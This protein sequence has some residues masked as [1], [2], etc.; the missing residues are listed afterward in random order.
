MSEVV[1]FT[2]ALL[3]SVITRDSIAHA[4]MQTMRKIKGSKKVQ[5]SFCWTAR[6]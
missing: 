6:V 5:R 1:P 3:E 2:L 4:S